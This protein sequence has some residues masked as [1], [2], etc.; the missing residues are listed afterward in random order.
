M[1]FRAVSSS[2]SIWYHSL[3]EELSIFTHGKAQGSVSCSSLN[4]VSVKR[5]F[6]QFLILNSQALKH[7]CSWTWIQKTRFPMHNPQDYPNNAHVAV[8]IAGKDGQL[9]QP[10]PRKLLSALFRTFFYKFEPE[11]LS[12]SET[13]TIQLN[14]THKLKRPV[15]F[16][17]D[18]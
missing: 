8:R 16:N 18:M 4:C 6:F 1:S 15:Y 2:E 7:L 5:E 14:N 17:T 10:G 13:C 12:R 3:K 11:W 9:T